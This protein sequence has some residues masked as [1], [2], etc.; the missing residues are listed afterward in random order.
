MRRGGEKQAGIGQQDGGAGAE[1]DCSQSGTTEALQGYALAH[2]KRQKKHSSHA[3]TERCDVPRG[4]A[5]PQAEAG[6]DDP[7][8][9]DA[10][11]GEPVESATCVLCNCARV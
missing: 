2:H 6:R 9:P 4:E 11:S 8:R 5:R 3:E 7:S 1:H 10:Y